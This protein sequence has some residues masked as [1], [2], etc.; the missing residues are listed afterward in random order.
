MYIPLPFGSVSFKPL[1][2]IHTTT[3]RRLFLRAAYVLAVV[4]LASGL[5]PAAAQT[6]VVGTGNPDVD[7]PAVQA[8]VNQ[9]GD[10]ILKG[11]FSFNS[12]ATIQTAL[13]SIGLPPA[14]VL[15][16]GAVT[17]S[18]AQDEDDERATIEGGSIPLYVDA[19][20][21]SVTIKGLR[22]IRPVAEAILVY[23]ANG[24]TIT[25]CKIEGVV[26]FPAYGGATAI[27]IDT[28]G[29]PPT[30]A[31][32]GHPE[33][34]FGRVSVTHNEIDVVGGSAVE[35]SLGIVVYSVGQSPDYEADIYISG[36]K[37]KNTTE[38]AMNFRHIGGRVYVEGND[39]ETGPVTSTVAGRPNVIRAVNTGSYVIA[40]N[41]ILCEWSAPDASGIGVFSQISAWPMENAIVRD[42]S[43]TMSPPPGVTFVAPS[44]GIEIMGFTSGNVVENNK[45][46]GSARAAIAVDPFNGGTPSNNTLIRNRV[47][48]FEASS[49]DIFIGQGVTDT[50]LVEQEGT[51]E[52]EGVGTQILP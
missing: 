49:A 50:L 41:R 38:P 7:V 34:I 32:P 47:D 15:V 45:V 6:V 21:A 1:E 24:L 5:K 8:A 44:A 2:L 13:A 36:N 12:T 40:H 31:N 14:M 20:G 26:P 52:D 46:R 30:V 23:A 3:L 16:S 48:D 10:V 25:N 37:I 35:D 18:G 27:D 42:N 22:F 9:G 11:N 28:T 29:R 4:V 33:N 19:P 43:V 17:I 39:I 51:V